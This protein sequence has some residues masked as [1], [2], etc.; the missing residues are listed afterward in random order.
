MNPA[1]SGYQ[2]FNKWEL[3][4][5]A[6]AEAGLSKAARNEIKAYCEAAGIKLEGGRI[7]AENWKGANRRMKLT[8]LDAELLIQKRTKAKKQDLYTVLFIVAMSLFLLFFYLR[9][10]LGFTQPLGMLLYLLLGV[11]FLSLIL[12]FQFREYRERKEKLTKSIVLK[13]SKDY[14]SCYLDEEGEIASG[15]IK[16][17]KYYRHFDSDVDYPSALDLLLE[18][19]CIIRLDENGS[20]QEL[21]ELAD[22]LSQESGIRI[23]PIPGHPSKKVLNLVKL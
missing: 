7:L 8:K 9:E 19:G 6:S 4:Y 5:L 18:D 11:I 17:I 14:V 10:L 21:F 12:W 23:L 2:L 16:K 20:Y 22:S 15:T 13:V 3:R 1:V